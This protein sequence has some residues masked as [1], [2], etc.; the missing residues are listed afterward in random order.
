MVWFLGFSWLLAFFL[1]DSTPSFIVGGV[2]YITREVVLHARPQFGHIAVPEWV[3]PRPFGFP[4][5]LVLEFT[6][7]ALKFMGGSRCCQNN[8]GDHKW[9]YILTYRNRLL[10][11]CVFVPCQ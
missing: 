8:P 7:E 9:C 10:T 5:N 11:Y 6:P 3:M 2:R 4:W 1:E